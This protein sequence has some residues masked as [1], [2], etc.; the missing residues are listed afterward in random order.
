LDC[1][2]FDGISDTQNRSWGNQLCRDD[3]VHVLVLL[4]VTFLCDSSEGKGKKA[5]GGE[6]ALL[7]EQEDTVKK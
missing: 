1:E 7:H 2:R 5:K 4:I 3:I 6:Q